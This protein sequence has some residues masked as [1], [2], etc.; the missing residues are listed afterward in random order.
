MPIRRRGR[1]RPA[2][3]PKLPGTTLPSAGVPMA[4]IYRP[5]RSETQSAP[6]PRYW[7]LEFEPASAPEREPLM[8][9]TRSDDP[10]RPV[11]L[12]F[13]DA[14]SAIAFAERHDWSYLLFEDRPARHIVKGIRAAWLARA[15]QPVPPRAAA[16]PK[17]RPPEPYDP[18]EEADLESFPA[19]DPPSWTGTTLNSGRRDRTGPTPKQDA[20]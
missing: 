19:S 14:A 16:G 6:R 3:R 18:V 4:L 9:W 20:G 10:F 17:E 12:R 15:T 1:N 8:G 7:L 13:P 2:G 11:R 5:A